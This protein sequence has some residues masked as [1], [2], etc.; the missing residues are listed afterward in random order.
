VKLAD[1]SVT[2]SPLPTSYVAP[3]GDHEVYLAFD[4]INRVLFVPNN[5]DM[6]QSPL[7]GLGIYHVDSGQ[8]EW[9]AVPP[10]VF[11]SVWGFDENTGA[12]IGIG[13]RVQ[14]SAYFL[15]KYK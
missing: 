13:K 15:Y 6:G 8:W 10:A 14:P 2:T 4:P 12:L 7:I 1:G 3:P 5:P 11:G 9:E